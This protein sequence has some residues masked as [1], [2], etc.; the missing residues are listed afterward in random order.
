MYTWGCKILDDNYNNNNKE[1]SCTGVFR[2]LHGNESSRKQRQRSRME[3]ISFNQK[4]SL[5]S[6]KVMFYQ[7]QFATTLIY[8]SGDG[9]SD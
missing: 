3:S 7:F 8:I 2:S 6:Q 5:P 9:I 4:A 1:A